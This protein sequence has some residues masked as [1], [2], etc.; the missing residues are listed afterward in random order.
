MGSRLLPAFNTTTG[1]PNPRVRLDGGTVHTS[2][3]TDTT[4]ASATSLIL[5]FGTLSRLT[6]NDTYI[7]LAREATESVWKMRNNITGR[8]S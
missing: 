2:D 7:K 8:D 1:I 4:V 3:S 6:G 5:E